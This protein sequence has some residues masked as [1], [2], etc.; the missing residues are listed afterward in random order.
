MGGT[1]SLQLGGGEPHQGRGSRFGSWGA[2]VSPQLCSHLSGPAP[3]PPHRP[4]EAR[5]SALETRNP[6]LLETPAN[7]ADPG[8]QPPPNTSAAVDQVPPSVSHM[9]ILHVFV[10]NRAVSES[11]GAWESPRNLISV[12]FPLKEIIYK[13][14]MENTL[15]H[16]HTF[17]F[18]MGPQSR[19]RRAWK[20]P[21]LSSRV[22]FLTNLSSFTWEFQF[23]TVRVVGIRNEADCPWE[24]VYRFRGAGGRPQARPCPGATSSSWTQML[25]ARGSVSG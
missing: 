1:L 14:L 21:H 6:H 9:G 25:E 8:G 16:K 10:H 24:P 15:P 22:L 4:Q 17:T 7:L 23:P 3:S 5:C 19:A 18:Q 20:H 2:S 12:Y 11:S 13:R